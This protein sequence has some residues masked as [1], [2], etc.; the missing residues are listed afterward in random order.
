MEREIYSFQCSA[1]DVTILIC[2][3]CEKKV[4]LMKIVDGSWTHKCCI[5]LQVPAKRTS[6]VM[7][8]DRLGCHKKWQQTFQGPATW[9][10][11]GFAAYSA[12][13]FQCPKVQLQGRGKLSVLDDLVFRLQIR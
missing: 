4:V 2:S 8:A 9:L 5:H 11:P 7:P 3:A 10:L 12:H 13:V 6:Q 1:E